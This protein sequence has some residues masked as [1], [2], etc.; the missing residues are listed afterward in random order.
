MLYFADLSHVHFKCLLLPNLIPALF[1]FWSMDSWVSRI[2]RLSL[3]IFL[4][5][6]SFFLDQCGCSSIKRKRV[7]TG[8]KDKEKFDFLFPVRLVII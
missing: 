5:V 6:Q 4:I 8:E 7:K 1:S 2:I 3:K